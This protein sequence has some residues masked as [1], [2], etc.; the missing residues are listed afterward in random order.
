VCVI[1]IGAQS[2]YEGSS[3]LSMITR[4]DE[5]A[6]RAGIIMDVPPHDTTTSTDLS[7]GT[8][9]PLP[10]CVPASKLS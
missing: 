8:C 6:Y 1:I 7:A 3:N 5:L 9:Y 4:V 2:I 10:L